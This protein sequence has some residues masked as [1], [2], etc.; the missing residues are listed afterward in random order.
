MDL[1]ALVEREMELPHL[2]RP[3]LAFTRHTTR[4]TARFAGMAS[5]KRDPP[6]KRVRFFE[7]IDCLLL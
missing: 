6:T 5:Y 4:P 1:Q 2:A 7:K 3:S